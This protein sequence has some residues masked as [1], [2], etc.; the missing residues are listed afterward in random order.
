M[1]NKELYGDIPKVT[2]KI[3]SRRL[4]YAGHCKSAK[5]RIV[6]DL[7]TWRP[8]QG[9]RAKGRPKKTFMDLLQDDTGYTLGE[10]ETSMQ[11][12]RFW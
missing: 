7:V 10:I 5:G 12:R 2:A 3:S 11:D 1:T 4:Q 6:S 9:R 8:T